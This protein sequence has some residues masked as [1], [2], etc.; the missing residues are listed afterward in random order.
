MDAFDSFIIGDTGN[1]EFCFEN[2]HFIKRL[3]D[4]RI[5]REYIV[6]TIFYEDPI[7]YEPS[8]QNMYEVIYPAPENKDYAE[9]KVVLACK[10]N[11]ID[12]VTVIPLGKTN[13]QK[14]KYKSDSY[15]KVEKK[16]IQAMQ[17]R[18]Y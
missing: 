7:R 10:G 17:K 12:L 1:I 3:D 8:G 14:N 16:R 4:N 11:K 15:K 13:R 6:D 9:I 18:K 2:K 5:S